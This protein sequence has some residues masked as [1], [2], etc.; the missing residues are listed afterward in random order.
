MTEIGSASHA[1]VHPFEGSRQL[2]QNKLATMLED[3]LPG[4]TAPDR[5]TD[6]KLNPTVHQ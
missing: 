3:D 2:L 6:Q 1:N 5:Q 4:E